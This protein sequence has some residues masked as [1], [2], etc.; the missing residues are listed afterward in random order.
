VQGSAT[1]YLCV[2]N[3][4]VACSHI[5]AWMFH[6]VM[7]SKLLMCCTM[8]SEYLLTLSLFFLAQ[9]FPLFTYSERRSN[10]Y[11]YQNCCFDW[12][13]IIKI[14]IKNLGR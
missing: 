11:S 7:L 10:L 2:P 9:S 4:L 14:K 8:C 13:I 3:V 6:H 5:F 1:F 12:P